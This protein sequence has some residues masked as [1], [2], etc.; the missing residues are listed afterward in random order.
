MAVGRFMQEAVSKDYSIWWQKPGTYPANAQKPKPFIK[1]GERPISVLENYKRCVQGNKP[2]WMPLYQEEKNIVWPD[3]IVEH[4]VPE[5]DGYDWW[6]TY[7]ADVPAGMA[8]AAD[9]RVVNDWGNWEAELEWPDIELVDWETDGKKISSTFD[10]QRAH[11][12]ECNEGLFERIH[13][14]IPF[15]ESLLAFYTEP[16]ATE[17]FFKKMVEYKIA[18]IEKVFKYYGRVDGVLYHDDW[19]T[20]RASFFS[21]QMFEEQILPFEKQ[22]VDYVK[23][24]G[25]FLELHS[26]GNNMVLVPLM[27]KMGIDMWAPQPS[28]NDFDYL[29]NNYNEEISFAFGVPLTADMNEEEVKQACRNFVDKFGPNGRVMAWVRRGSC[30]PEYMDI[31]NQEIVRYSMEY[32]AKR[33]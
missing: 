7:W 17:R 27:I 23:S 32:Y 4:P 10:P 33:W 30:K 6:G 18:T 22:I 14:L 31:A 1:E 8:V 20:Q 19:G 16:E 21:P 25:R 2:L 29:F 12:Y 9:T 24:Q 26:C 13:E 11:V 3:C 28:A 5:A 15:D